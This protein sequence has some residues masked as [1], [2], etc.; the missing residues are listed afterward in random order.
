MEAQGVALKC[1]NC[2]APLD[3]SPDS[4]MTI[5]RYCGATVSMRK[6]DV[7]MDVLASLPLS[8]I[9]QRV[10]KFVQ[11]NTG[12]VTPLER[13]LV[14]VPVF[15]ANTHVKGVAV[16]VVDQKNQRT[17]EIP[18][19]RDMRVAIYGRYAPF[20]G[21][22]SVLREFEQGNV[23]IERLKTLPENVTILAAQKT[24]EEIEREARERAES[25][26]LPSIRIDIPG[27][28]SIP[29]STNVKFWDAKVDVID[30]HGYFFPMFVYTWRTNGARF[31]TIADGTDGSVVISRLPIPNWMRYGAVG[32]STLAALLTGPLLG[33]GHFG[34]WL[35]LGAGVL[36]YI[37]S[38][39]AVRGD[40]TWKR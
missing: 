32:V 12:A 10:Y 30:I 21:V 24:R 17:Q 40:R 29:V 33:A 26:A 20:F 15:T 35:P 16:V 14:Y 19:E 7:P 23:Q 36:A 28:G 2:G 34:I 6:F 39:F 25:K 4:V 13:K 1:P 18:I 37:A 11:R 8:E 38:W 9:E 5:C 3:V 22:E 31:V 27:L